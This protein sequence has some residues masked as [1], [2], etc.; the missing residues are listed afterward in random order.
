MGGRSLLGAVLLTVAL[1]GSGHAFAQSS[2]C[3]FVAGFADLRAMIEPETVGDCL[4]DEQ[5]DVYG[6]VAQRTTRG[7]LWWTKSDSIASFTDE[8]TTWR[9]GPFGLQ[10]R[11]N[12]DR[13]RWEF[14]KRTDPKR[15][16]PSQADIAPQEPDPPPPGHCGESPPL[17]P[18]PPPP[19]AAQPPPRVAAAPGRYSDDRGVVLDISVGS[20]RDGV[21]SSNQFNRPRGRWAVLNWQVRN[22]GTSSFT[23]NPLYLQLQ[24]QDDSLFEKGNHAGLP[25]PS[26]PLVTL[27]PG[28]SVRGY[29]AYDLPRGQRVKAAVFQRYGSPLFTVALFDD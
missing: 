5:T 19:A 15:P 10:S 12:Q 26:F 25:E 24:T 29:V 22:E 28:Q 20:L 3:Q 14:G 2:P 6:D 8:T 13:F 1:L 27:G 16:Q 18:P 7:T 17:A 4:E 9:N 11:S 21:T 23:V